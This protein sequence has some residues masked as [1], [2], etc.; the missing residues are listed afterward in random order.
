[1]DC[2]GVK[3]RNKEPKRVL[4]VKHYQS[5]PN[6]YLFITISNHN[7]HGKLVFFSSYECQ[8]T[9]SKNSFDPILSFGFYLGCLKMY[10]YCVI[11]SQFCKGLSKGFI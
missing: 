8:G 2:K 5:K 4:D 9:Y 1:M 6:I 10:T 11:W 3:T 7:N